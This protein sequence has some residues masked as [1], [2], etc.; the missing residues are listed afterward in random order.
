[1]SGQEKEPGVIR[2]LWTALRLAVM[3][4]VIGG[5]IYPLVITGLGQ[6]LFPAQANGSLIVQNGQVV[7][8]AL[9]GQSF[10]SPRFFQGRPSATGYAANAS[11]ASN[12]GPTNPTLISDVAA[13]LQGVLAANPGLSVAQ[14]PVDLVESSD[15]GVDPDISIQAAL[16]QVPRVAAQNGLSQ[17]VVLALVKSQER[18]RFLGLFGAPH[19]N[20]LEL[21]LRLE[22]L[23]GGGGGQG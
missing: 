14:V 23:I 16:V 8:S 13:A 21:N 5:L 3:F 10:T 19:V 9:I 17:A 4:A 2:H 7:G 1:M 15:S 12:L 11:S 6:L 20:V 22:A 18:G